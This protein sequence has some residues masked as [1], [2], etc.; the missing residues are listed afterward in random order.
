LI[1][2][3]TIGRILDAAN[4]VEVVG[5]F[6]ALKKRGTNYIGLCPFHNEKTPSFTVSPS[7]GI[8]KCFGCGAGGNSVN[9]IMELENLSYPEAL[10]FLAKK[11]GIPIEEKDLTDEEKEDKSRLESLRIVNEFAAKYFNNTLLNSEEGTAI[12]LSYFKERGIDRT[13]I[14]KFNLGYCPGAGSEFTDAATKNGYKKDLL[15]ELGLTKKGQYSDFDF[16]KGRVMFPIHNLSGHVIAFGGRTLQST[17]EIAKYFNSPESVLYHKS[18]VLYGIFQAKKAI[19]QENKCYLVEGYTDVTS[20]FQAGIENV[21]A[22]SGTALTSGQIRLIKRFTSNITILYDGDAAGINAAL[23]GIDLVLEQG[24]NVRV[25]LLPE[26]EDPDSFSKSVSLVELKSYIETQEKDFIHFKAELLLHQAGNDPVKRAEVTRSIVESIAKVPDTF[27]RNEFIRSTSQIL[28]IGEEVL[29]QEIRKKIFKQIEKSSDVVPQTFRQE[30]STS[31]QTQDFVDS[32]QMYFQEIET[33][34]LKYLIKYPNNLLSVEAEFGEIKTITCAQ[35]LFDELFVDEINFKNEIYNEMFHLAFEEWRSKGRLSQDFFV[36]H[37]KPYVSKTAVNIIASRHEL[38]IMYE[39]QNIE[40]LTEE[41]RLNLLLP[42]NIIIYK[43][44]SLHMAAKSIELKL[45]KLDSEK[46]W[47]QIMVLTKQLV[48]R[49][50]ALK[51]IS[52]LIKRIIP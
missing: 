12:G 3:Q 33:A 19:S 28:S 4:I 46:D 32:E 38:S 48:M 5:D 50:N 47:D 49:K 35:Y 15:Y 20:M 40:I 17:K 9:F 16:Y 6:V 41:D 2:Q 14:N 37:P 39:K 36:L 43:S 30:Q 1:D 8:C 44:R 24:M 51:E 10:K 11:Y 26:G 42:N 27:L 7:K 25:V 13:T 23:K 34:L 22:S 31:S 45:S 18:D 21:V 52:K 29:N